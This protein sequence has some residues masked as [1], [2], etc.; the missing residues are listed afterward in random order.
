MSKV[1]D[2]KIRKLSPELRRE[3]FSYV[4]RHR[5]VGM[6]YHTLE[7]ILLAYRREDLCQQLK[8]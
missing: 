5:L 7:L 8:Q 6:D 4:P 1:T 2:W 3:L